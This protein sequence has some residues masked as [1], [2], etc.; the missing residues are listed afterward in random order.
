MEKVDSHERNIWQRER[1]SPSS[2]S[3]HQFLIS[4][5][6]W[7]VPRLTFGVEK[8]EGIQ[9]SVTSVKSFQMELKWR[10][11]LGVGTGVLMETNRRRKSS[12]K[13]L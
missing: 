9:S 10:I 13:L 2:K 1:P 8:K 3:H 4:A 5:P 7:R 6:S 12:Q 11:S